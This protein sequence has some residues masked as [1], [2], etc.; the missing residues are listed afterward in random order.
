[1]RISLIKRLARAE[2]NSGIFDVATPALF[3]R[4]VDCSVRDPDTSE[5]HEPFDHE[6]HVIGV[7]CGPSITLKGARVRA[8]RV[9]RA[10]SESI[11]ALEAR[12]RRLVPDAVLFFHAYQSIP[13]SPEA[14]EQ[15]PEAGAGAAS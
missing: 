14:F 1:M 11:E 9:S 4:V 13:S 6:A 15:L 8:Q 5:P 10:E 7:T 3:V 12:A 2:A